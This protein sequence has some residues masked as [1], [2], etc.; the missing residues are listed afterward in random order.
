M[1]YFSYIQKIMRNTISSVWYGTYI[2]LEYIGTVF[3]SSRIEKTEG[4]AAM[5]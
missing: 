2:F 4:I 1:V 5:F 3:R